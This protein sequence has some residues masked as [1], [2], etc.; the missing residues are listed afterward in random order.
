MQWEKLNFFCKIV[1]RHFCS[2][3]WLVWTTLQI[4]LRMHLRTAIAQWIRLRLP[5]CGPGFKSP[6]TPSV[7]LK[8]SNLVPKICDCV[9]NRRQIKQ[10]REAG[11][12]H[13]FWKNY[14]CPSY[15]RYPVSRFFNKRG[16]AEVMPAEYE[17]FQI[18]RWDS[19]PGHGAL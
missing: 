14:K 15:F 1:P 16:E 2:R 5:F 18:E 11:L 10:K 13:I 6:S 19:L 8:K 12:A 4:K 3:L 17:E 7:L 9:E